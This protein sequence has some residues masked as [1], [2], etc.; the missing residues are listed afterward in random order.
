MRKTRHEAK[1]N[2][3]SSEV[4]REFIDV[5]QKAIKEH[6]GKD[7]EEDPNVP[8]KMVMLIEEKDGEHINLAAN[9]DNPLLTEH[10]VMEV[11]AGITQR[12]GQR[13]LELMEAKRMFDA[14]NA[15][16]PRGGAA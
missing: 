8:I 5:V 7:G 3:P 1:V 6:Y 11:A 9:N 16:P 2:E 13:M 4:V 12:W 15:M 10:M 14:L